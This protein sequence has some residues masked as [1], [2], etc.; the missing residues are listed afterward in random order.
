M[1][2]F[3]YN[4]PNCGGH[5]KFGEE[6]FGK[7]GICPHC[8]TPVTIPSQAPV[9]VDSEPPSES[10]RKPEQGQIEVFPELPDSWNRLVSAEEFFSQKEDVAPYIAAK[11]RKR[12]PI[13]WWHQNIGLVLLLV[14]SLS[15][16]KG[17]WKL[18]R[19]LWQKTP[20]TPVS[21]EIKPA[22]VSLAGVP[23]KYHKEIE[24]IGRNIKKGDLATAV[25]LSEALM[26]TEGFVEYLKQNEEMRSAMVNWIVG[27]PLTLAKNNESNPSTEQLYAKKAT[28][29]YENFV[30][31]GLDSGF[32]GRFFNCK[33]KYVLL[34]KADLSKPTG[35]SDFA[36]C[37]KLLTAIGDIRGRE[38]LALKS[39]PKDQRRDI[40]VMEGFTLARRLYQPNR[41]FA[42]FDDDKPNNT[43][44]ERLD[45]LI[46]NW[47]KEMDTT[48]DKEFF[49]LKKFFYKTALTFRPTKIPILGTNQEITIGAWSMK[50][51]DIKDIIA[52][53]D[54]IEKSLEKSK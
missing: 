27:V 18:V 26:K 36:S 48:T 5:I 24:E 46:T 42:R 25:N 10:G 7:E 20:V 29:N 33:A 54:T 52:S 31:L 49:D 12:R 53:I 8:S 47:S 13:N 11:A 41:W 17:D 28:E 43:R 50:E 4:C 44:W 3:R 39:A 22:T 34:G 9:P 32:E 35:K 2:D 14:V 15:V 30:H 21:P 1:S 37:D 40:Y 51:K 6:H 38:G 45:E 19:M 23:E 16:F